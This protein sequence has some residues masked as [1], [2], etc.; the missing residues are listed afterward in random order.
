MY[1]KGI[2]LQDV[3]PGYDVNASGS[4][5]KLSMKDRCRSVASYVRTA[6]PDVA[7]HRTAELLTRTLHTNN[8]RK[9]SQERALDLMN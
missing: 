3:N 2:W 6:F 8:K 5:M 7:E 4:D 9:P 1:T